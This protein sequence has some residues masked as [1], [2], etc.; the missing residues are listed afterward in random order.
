MNIPAL[1]PEDPAIWEGQQFE[2]CWVLPAK[3]NVN[4][5][6]LRLNKL[7]DM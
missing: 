6:T 7:P 5:K 4:P 2:V 1:D 3:K